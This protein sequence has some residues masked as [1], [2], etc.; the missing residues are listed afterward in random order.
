MSLPEHALPPTRPEESLSLLR[1]ENMLALRYPSLTQGGLSGGLYICRDKNYSI[2]NVAR[3]FRSAVKA[4]LAHCEIRPLL[5]AELLTQGLECNRDTMLRQGRENAEFSDPRR[6]QRF[7]DAAWQVP[8]IEVTGAFVDG[9]LAAYQLG[10]LDDGCWNIAYAFS[11]TS[12]LEHRP[13]HALMFS[14]LERTLRRADVAAVCAGP[15]TVLVEDGLHDFKTRIGFELEPHQVVIRFHPALESALVSWPVMKLARI[16]RTTR[17]ANL[18]F[19]RAEAFLK[20][21]RAA[22]TGAGMTE[23]LVEH[24]AG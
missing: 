1:Q 2:Q 13:N 23:L 3:G 24:G 15:K 5:P 8:A 4:G 16:L 14:T 6:W 12:L 21:A 7:V 10:C 18:Q 22:R 19:M 17:P 11:R 9:R 20:A